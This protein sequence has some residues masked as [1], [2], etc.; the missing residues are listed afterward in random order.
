[1]KQPRPGL[2]Y[3]PVKDLDRTKMSFENYT[4]DDPATEKLG[5]LEGFIIDVD[6]AVPYYTVVDAGG[7]FRSKHFLVPIGHVTLDSD[8]KTLIA[9]ISKERV[10]R[11]PGFDLGLFPKLTQEDLDHMA[12]EIASVC[13]P[14]D[15]VMEPG[16]FIS[17]VEV[18]A[19]YRTPVWWDTSF[20][21]NRPLKDEGAPHKAESRR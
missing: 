7:W 15:V 17:R 13:C 16:E 19:H 12:D 10:K 2:R 8:A 1:M 18:W 6:K 5:K 11:F 14:D 4:V 3:M 9:D 21:T 20:Y